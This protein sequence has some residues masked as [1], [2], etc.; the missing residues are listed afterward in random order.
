MSHLLVIKN[1]DGKILAEVPVESGYTVQEIP[2][3]TPKP[4]GPPD[5]AVSTGDTGASKEKIN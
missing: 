5:K 2:K 3:K 4:A 1:K